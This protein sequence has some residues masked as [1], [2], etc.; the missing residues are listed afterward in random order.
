MKKVIRIMIM[1]ASGSIAFFIFVIASVFTSG[2]PYYFV[3]AFVLSLFVVFWAM[4]A[5]ITLPI[6]IY[7]EDSMIILKTLSG[8]KRFKIAKIEPIDVH[9]FLIG[10]TYGIGIDTNNVKIGT[11]T[12]VR[13]EKVLAYC[14]MNKGIFIETENGKKFVIAVDGVD[15]IIK[16]LEGRSHVQS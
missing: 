5:V 9:S 2:V 7:I 8:K 14:V 1:I 16:K 11:F 10:R 6:D 13:R 15:K 12:T 3:P 4:W